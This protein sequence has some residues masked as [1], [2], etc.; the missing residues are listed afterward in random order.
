MNYIVSIRHAT[1]LWSPRIHIR[2]HNL[3]D[4]ALLRVLHFFPRASHHSDVVSIHSRSIQSERTFHLQLCVVAHIH[5]VGDRRATV[6]NVAASLQL[7]HHSTRVF[8]NVAKYTNLP[9]TLVSLQYPSVVL[10]VHFVESEGA[11]GRNV[12]RLINRL[13]AF[14][15]QTGQSL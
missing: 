5:V 2:A 8:G 13:L 6:G 12:L 7:L 9:S 10:G 1:L 15:M 4:I 11:R 3:V 14:R